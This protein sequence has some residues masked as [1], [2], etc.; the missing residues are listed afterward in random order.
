MHLEQSFVTALDVRLQPTENHRPPFCNIRICL[1]I[2]CKLIVH[3]THDSLAVLF[4]KR[5]S[6]ARG[7]TFGDSGV[8]RKVKYCTS[9][10]PS[11]Q[12]TT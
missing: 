8:R 4:A 5:V 3:Q 9:S 11:G 2:A 10:E 1:F 6:H 7:L 12:I